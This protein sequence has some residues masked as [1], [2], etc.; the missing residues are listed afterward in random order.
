MGRARRLVSRILGVKSSRGV[1]FTLSFLSVLS[2]PFGY[3]R[4]LIIAWL[5]GAS[6]IMDA[7]QLALG[8]IALLAGSIG[9]AMQHAVLPELERVRKETG[10]AG[11]CRSLLAFSAWCAV[12]MTAI[13]CAALFIAPGV[14][15]KAF[16]GGFD[17]ERIRY[18]AYMIWWLS[19]YAIVTMVAPIVTVWAL[20]TERYVASAISSLP[21]NFVIIPLLLLS[22]PWIG[23][24]AMGLSQSAAS[25]ILFVI[26]I[27]VIRGFPMR[28]AVSDLP[29]ASLRR[30]GANTLLV[31]AM[32]ATSTVYVVVDRYFASLL[33]VG[34]VSSISY[35]N[36]LTV[37]FT[38]LVSAPFGFF[39]ARISRLANED[40]EEAISAVKQTLAIVSAYILPAG[41]LS[42][43][44]ARP[45]VSL[46]L[47][48]GSFGE[49][50]VT[51][52]SMSLTG[53]NISMVFSF[54][55]M[56]L[57]IYA[58]ATQRL[59][60]LLPVSY[61]MIAINALL[62]WLMVMPLGVLGLALATSIT[63][64]LS[65]IAT[66]LILIDRSIITF[67]AQIRFFAQL[68]VLV[69]CGLAVYFS[70]PL[71]TAAQFAV[72]AAISAVYFIAG[73]R[74]GLMSS[75]PEHWRPRALLCYV[76]NT[77]GNLLKK[78]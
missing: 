73:E 66:Y 47:G 7:F 60:R 35:G 50:A 31:L 39:F 37:A 30:I 17:A 53:Y 42:S 72:F 32:T 71:G 54:F 64:M 65:F 14:M 67:L 8:V 43:A 25:V 26:T 41:I 2:K 75:V 3:A 59:V 22:A 20:F 61:V 58:Q 27:I 68:A 44:A 15:I 63:T 18:G 52:T 62:D 49:D 56:V 69:P 11:K 21:Y 36:M 5:F 38:S 55:G 46:F 48:W 34:A 9:G 45:L 33:P 74:F 78:R 16:A 13:L 51:M 70:E 12:I 24:Y 1:S 28:F 57:G 29:L 23:A 4:I 40:H 19:P 10:S 76:R 77:G 6:A